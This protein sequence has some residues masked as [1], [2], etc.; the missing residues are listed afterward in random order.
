MQKQ[1]RAQPEVERAFE[2]FRSK[3][4]DEAKLVLNERTG[5]P[6]L[7]YD[8]KSEPLAGT[9][10]EA[11]RNFIAEN[12]TLLL[13]NEPPAALQLLQSREGGGATHVDFRQSY[14]GIPV[15][16][17]TLS[18]HLTGNQV[19]MVNGSYY[20]DLS[21][22][23]VPTATAD[24][25]LNA[26]RTDLNP[27]GAYAVEA[28]EPELM[29]YVDDEV[30]TLCWRVRLFSSEPADMEYFIDAKTQQVLKKNN[31]MRSFD[32]QGLVYPVNPVRTPSLSYQP[33]R[34]LDGSG[35]LRG[36]YVRV[37]TFYNF[38]VNGQ[39]QIV[40]IQGV[41]TVYSP[42]LTYSYAPN[43]L[44]FSEQSSYYFINQ[45]HDY[46]KSAFGFTGRDSAIPTYVHFNP[47]GT[48]LNNAFYMPYF[49][50][51][52]VGDGSGSTSGATG[53][54]N[55]A[56]DSDL[57]Y[58]EYT[59]AVIGK[60]NASFG[61]D[62]Y[63]L[64][65]NE[66]YADYFACSQL[67]D[68]NQGEWLLQARP[69]LW[70]N[71]T[72][73]NKYPTNVLPPG[74]SD[75]EPHYAGMI[76]SGA[77]WDLRVALGQTIADK[78]AFGALFYFP[79]DGH[80][81]FEIGLQTLLAAD[82]A[83][84]G[85]AHVQTI[86]QKLN[87]RGI[88]EPASAN[89]TTIT[90]GVTYSGSIQVPDSRFC[91]IADRQYAIQVPSGTKSLT[92]EVAG[93]GN[94]DLYVRYGSAITIS[95]SQVVADFGSF[96]TSNNE[97]IVIDQTHT[98]ALKSGIY[99]IAV[100]DCAGFGINYTLRATLTSSGGTG[101]TDEVTLTAGTTITGQ[102][103]GAPQSEQ[104][105]GI[106]GVT[107]YVIDVPTNVT[108]LD[109]KLIGTTANTDIDL[110]VRRG[111][112]VQVDSNGYLLA[113]R[114]SLTPSNIEYV[115]TDSS[116]V[117]K[118]VPGSR[119]YI[120]IA[121][122][123]S[124]PGNFQLTAVLY[125][126]GGLPAEVALQSGVA[127]TGSLIGTP[128]PNQIIDFTN[129]VINVPPGASQLRV[130]LQ[131]NITSLVNLYIRAGSRVFVNS[132]S[133]VQD[134]SSS[135]AADHQSVIINTSSSPPLYSVPYFIAVGNQS[136]N[137]IN[138]T[139][140]A[141]VTQGAAHKQIRR[142][143]ATASWIIRS[144]GRALAG[145]CSMATSFIL[146]YRR[147]SAK[148]VRVST[149]MSG[150]IWRCWDVWANASRRPSSSTTFWRT[151]LARAALWCSIRRALRPCSRAATS[152]ASPIWRALSRTTV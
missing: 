11:A 87:A 58:H 54:N 145:S 105:G 120:A 35:Y 10:P 126:G 118:L 41:P 108:G 121:N 128:A 40:G 50:S 114:F 85:G 7:L 124:V 23:T 21:L 51:I 129:Y 14:K 91:F 1:G 101:G 34:Y 122:F 147:A 72:N 70:R 111:A 96:S 144:N 133:I 134:H 57:L 64:A 115:S 3:Y 12:K 71:L 110:L 36:S 24:E 60:I 146:T 68:P 137:T 112:R 38:V 46:F 86:R 100:S 151:R 76:W 28:R 45:M 18:V 62:N 127:R 139:L 84:Y 65:M 103:Q 123:S 55:P 102:V 9:G 26:A 42:T 116:T 73:T 136:P 32:G 53:I 117:P 97:T 47:D 8:F 149:E 4:G 99:Y 52:F 92:V 59:H 22:D 29:I 135:F 88:F 27:K 81:S 130:D 131:N 20:P 6:S 132:G 150:A 75:F 80:A 107:Q 69:D 48:A 44:R 113:D 109:V 94:A 56:F 39:G 82:S 2:S 95:N 78:I 37:S 83:L 67:N 30:P 25:A 16:P 5:L 61:N 31:L 142:C 119:Y 43:D 33:F 152:S 77:L 17:G 89:F 93:S 148:C 90:S 15:Q 63:G 141:T 74:T 49:D 143:F 140:T 125:G 66:G 13:K 104:Q 79:Q 138:F 19:T 106:L 98:P